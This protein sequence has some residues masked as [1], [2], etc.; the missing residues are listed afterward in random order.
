MRPITGFIED[1][2]NELLADGLAGV[3]RIPY[4]QA[5]RALDDP[6]A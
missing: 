6:S 1:E 2:A 3:K 4:E 5:L